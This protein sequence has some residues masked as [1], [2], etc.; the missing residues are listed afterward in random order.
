MEQQETFNLYLTTD[1][2]SLKGSL[3]DEISSKYDKKGPS[4]EK[5]TRQN[6]K[7]MFDPNT[8]Q[9]IVSEVSQTMRDN[10]ASFKKDDTLLFNYLK[11]NH[12]SRS[13]DSSKSFLLS[14]QGIVLQP[15][16]TSQKEDSDKK[17]QLDVEIAIEDIM[18]DLHPKNIGTT[19]FNKMLKYA[20]K[21]FVKGSRGVEVSSDF[22]GDDVAIDSVIGRFFDVTSGKR[23]TGGK[24]K[25]VREGRISAD[26]LTYSPASKKDAQQHLEII[27]QQDD[28]TR[29]TLS[30]F[31][32]SIE[33]YLADDEPKR[34]IT[35]VNLSG[36]YLIG[37][38]NLQSL[39]SREEIYKY[40]RGVYGD[41]E[42][43][44]EAFNAFIEVAK[45]E[46]FDDLGD[47]DTEAEITKLIEALKDLEVDINGNDENNLN[48]V[49]KVNAVEIREKDAQH[50]VNRLF[51]S[52]LEDMGL[53]EGKGAERIVEQE[54]ARMREE[55]MLDP[56][57]TA[58]TATEQ[59][60]IEEG[61]AE[62]RP[63]MES[64]RET[65]GRT[66]AERGEMGKQRPMI[67][68]LTDL[69]ELLEEQKDFYDKTPQKVDPLFAYA[70]N[71]ESA[72]FKNTAIMSQ[73]LDKLKVGIETNLFYLDIE[74]DD[75]ITEWMEKLNDYV[76][77]V[78]K[79]A[80]YY[81]PISDSL[82]STVVIDTPTWRKKQEN[83]TKFLDTIVGFIERGKGLERSSAAG[84][85]ESRTGDDPYKYDVIFAPSGNEKSLLDTEFISTFREEFDDL[86]EAVIDFYVI[87]PSG[88]YSPFDEEIDLIG[89]D[90]TRKTF[91]HLVRGKQDDGF[92]AILDKERGT[93]QDF[94][95]EEDIRR[96]SEILQ[97]IS[98]PTYAKNEKEFAKQ[99]RTLMKV[100]VRGVYG[101][102]AKSVIGLRL[103]EELGAYYYHMLKK[104]GNEEAGSAQIFGEDAQTWKD[105]HKENS[106]RAASPFVSLLNHIRRNSRGPDSIYMRGAS[107]E[108]KKALQM[109]NEMRQAF[110]IVKSETEMDILNAHDSIRKMIGKPIY[111]N[112]SKLD[113]FNHMTIAIDMMQKNYNVDVNAVEVENIVNEFGS[114]EQVGEKYGVP[115]ESVYFLK[116]NFR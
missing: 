86:L 112:T 61:T 44:K 3:Y 69:K 79:M 58:R 114:L 77:D 25:D 65:G 16:L 18:E 72:A 9:K 100:V 107:S 7:D 23:L 109:F 80:T 52:L 93:V 67:E 28:K 81:L 62:I 99:L 46:E 50:K 88:I 21:Q 64:E 113:N 13:E 91:S 103:K 47:D 32:D 12:S 19:V 1:S 68:V 102:S 10:M 95:D 2:K 8:A 70:F 57:E 116:A 78:P 98:S 49:Y 36:E 22:S 71:K 37:E 20:V 94:V 43:V 38:L 51:M 104:N 108:Q 60:S 30:G 15:H 41:Y 40:W 106:R 85:F 87:P 59:E 14:P 42:K 27:E 39:G 63:E 54:Y 84:G 89:N 4:E 83:I 6:V 96:I 82:K 33:A 90:S 73:E 34:K 26:E 75:D 5:V 53:A 105:A 24:I 111:Y 48:Y 101:K 92:F 110:N 97:D 115:S 17:T 35:P 76:T 29:S 66:Q 56:K 74:Y 31:A 11:K 45:P 55:G